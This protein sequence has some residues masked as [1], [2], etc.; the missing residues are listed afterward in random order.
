MGNMFVSFNEYARTFYVP[1]P[2]CYLYPKSYREIKDE[3]V[4]QSPKVE[5]LQPNVSR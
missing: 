4:L 3:L 5:D 2:T 1:N